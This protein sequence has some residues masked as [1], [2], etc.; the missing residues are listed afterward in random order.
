MNEISKSEFLILAALRL[1]EFKGSIFIFT[2]AVAQIV[3]NIRRTSFSSPN[4]CRT[5][6]KFLDRS[7]PNIVPCLSHTLGIMEMPIQSCRMNSTTHL[8]SKL[9]VKSMG[10]NLG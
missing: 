1:Q 6:L 2:P 10:M 5:E 4:K 9:L 7:T 8:R 3:V